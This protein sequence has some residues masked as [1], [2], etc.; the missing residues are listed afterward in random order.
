VPEECPEG[1]CFKRPDQPSC[2]VVTLFWVRP[3][4]ITT[5][6][7]TESR[8]V[9]KSGIIFSQHSRYG[10]SN[11][12]RARGLQLV[13]GAVRRQHDDDDDRKQEGEVSHCE[14]REEELGDGSSQRSVTTQRH[15]RQIVSGDA[16]RARHAHQHE[17]HAKRKQLHTHTHSTTGE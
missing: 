2:R 12:Q 7:G 6:S 15:H 17:R 8:K 1:D 4:Q 14:D 5:S 3:N 13:V 10:L 16:E 9:G 11:G